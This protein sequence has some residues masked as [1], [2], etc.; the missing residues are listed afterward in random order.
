VLKPLTDVMK[1]PGGK[2]KPI[3][4]TA[5]MTGAIRAVKDRLCSA[6]KLAHP[7]PAAEISLAVDASDWC[8]GAVLQQKEGSAWRP[9]AFYSKKLDAAQ[10]KYSAFDRELLAAYQAVRH[11]RFLLKGRQ[12][13]I[14]TDHKPLTYALKNQA[15]PWTARQQRQLSYLAE[16]TADLRHVAGNKNVVADTLSR[17]GPDGVSSPAAVVAL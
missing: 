8:V 6:T 7:D 11:F 15:E 16:F 4:W 9:L 3:T 12:F 10:H 17:P 14:Q 1:G 13:S 5:V 2:R